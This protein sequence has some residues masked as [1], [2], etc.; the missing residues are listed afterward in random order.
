MSRCLCPCWMHLLHFLLCSSDWHEP[1]LATFLKSPFCPCRDSSIINC[2]RVS[3]A[4]TR[5]FSTSSAHSLISPDT[6]ISARFL[7]LHTRKITFAVSARRMASTSS[8]GNNSISSNS[9]PTSKIVTKD[10]IYD[11]HWQL[12]QGTPVPKLKVFNSLTRSKVRS[13]AICN[14]LL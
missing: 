14:G 3:T 7:G 9:I 11:E 6:V 13:E 10:K 4:A 12:P 1:D 2:M 5:V 8:N